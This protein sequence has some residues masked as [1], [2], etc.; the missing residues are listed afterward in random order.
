MSDA[1][2]VL[3]ADNSPSMRMLLES[4]LRDL[5]YADCLQA[6]NGTEAVAAFQKH[7]PVLTFLDTDLPE[8]N[9]LAALSQIRAADAKAFVVMISANASLNNVKQ[10]MEQG[11][12][13]FIVKPYSPQ[14]VIEI[15]K[16]LP[17]A[18]R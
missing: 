14:K 6:S 9:G 7:R 3:I 15:L 1:P 11:V 8:L 17:S 16:K 18:A 12:N 13:G 10:A 4:I 2:K 5:N